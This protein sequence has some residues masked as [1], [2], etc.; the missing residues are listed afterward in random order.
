M[1]SPSSEATT[2][3][4]PSLPTPPESRLPTEIRHLAWPVAASR[5]ATVPARDAT[6]TLSPTSAGLNT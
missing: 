4:A 1:T 5:R 2:A 6:Y 3:S